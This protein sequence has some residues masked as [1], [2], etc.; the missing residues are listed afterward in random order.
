M[1][2]C[3]T[4]GSGRGWLLDTVHISLALHECTTWPS[5][6][7]LRGQ[8]NNL[9]AVDVFYLLRLRVCCLASYSERRRSSHG[10][11][12]EAAVKR[13]GPARARNASYS[14]S[15]NL[16]M[17][18]SYSHM[19]VHYLLPAHLQR[20]HAASSLVTADTVSDSLARCLS[21]A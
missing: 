11:V 1:L 14:I 5:G 10:L 6:A 7:H 21:T 16:H 20:L 4:A 8:L 18:S 19:C 2:C 3:K 9:H 13:R 17:W 12:P 15:C